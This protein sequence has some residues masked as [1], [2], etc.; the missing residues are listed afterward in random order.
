MHRNTFITG[1][2]LA[3]T[4][5]AGTVASA[6]RADRPDRPRGEQSDSSACSGGARGRG[7]EQML[8]KGITLSADQK[9]RIAVLG[10]Q[11]RKQ[12]DAERAKRQR[13]NGQARPERQRGDTTG[14]GARR[15]EMEQRREQHFASIRS[16]LDNNQRVQFDKNIAELKTRMSQRGEKRGLGHGG[17]RAGE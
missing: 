12:F 15:A 16:I 1:A 5:A 2:A 14:F 7:G 9:T 8:L 6:Q 3:L 11:Q 17:K 10:E 4:M 13:Q